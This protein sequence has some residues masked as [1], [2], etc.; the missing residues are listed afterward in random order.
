MSSAPGLS[1]YM[2]AEKTERT[3]RGLKVYRGDASCVVQEEAG[4]VL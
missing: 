3:V 4:H 2:R 1:D